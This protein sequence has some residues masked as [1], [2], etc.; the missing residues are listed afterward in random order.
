MLA[1]PAPHLHASSERQMPRRKP[2]A[3][4]TTQ[5]TISIA[6]RAMRYAASPVDH[7]P[8]PLWRT[9]TPRPAEH[10]ALLTPPPYTSQRGDSQQHV[11]GMGGL[12]G[13]AAACYALQDHDQHGALHRAARGAVSSAALF[14]LPWTLRSLLWPRIRQLTSML[15]DRS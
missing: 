2:L 15:Q 8:C 14:A 13:R 12:H 5:Q 3:H 6:P 11:A 10:L 9:H 7:H 4:V 1:S